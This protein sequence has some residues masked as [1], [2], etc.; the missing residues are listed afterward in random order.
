[1]GGVAS[2]SEL[3]RL[4]GVRGSVLK[5]HLDRLIKFNIVEGEV[6]GTYKLTFKT[7]LCWLFDSKIEY[8]YLGLL[9][10]RSG[11]GEPE[12]ETAIKLLVDQGITPK[13]IYVVT[14]MAALSEWAELK[15]PYN[16]ILCYEEELVDID[17]IIDKV[18][19][20]LEALIK[21]YIVIMDCTSLTKPA[22]IAYYQLAI[23]YY[24][25]LIYIYEDTKQLKWLI[26][27]DKLK[28]LLNIV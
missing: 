5:Y 2:F 6:K 8:I 13:L 25:P 10:R 24:I 4:S 26:S 28:T 15:L 22:T 27:K 16:W 3:E 20:Q 18:R 11:R 23:T 1:K 12:P 14:S 21:D 9:G 7:P 17:S 19:P